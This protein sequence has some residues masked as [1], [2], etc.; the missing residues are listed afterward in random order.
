M[1]IAPG[2]HMQG[3]P[4]RFIAGFSKPPWRGTGGR[5]VT[6]AEWPRRAWGRW[7]PELLRTEREDPEPFGGLLRGDTFRV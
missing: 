4:A 7:P 5:T 1:E 6:C 3:H 2:E